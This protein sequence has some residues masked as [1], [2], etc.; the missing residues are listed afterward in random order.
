MGNSC[1]T[2]RWENLYPT[3]DPCWSCFEL[4]KWELKTHDQ[5][6]QFKE[7]SE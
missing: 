4:D 3:F 7:D 2:C 5:V 1:R 6:S